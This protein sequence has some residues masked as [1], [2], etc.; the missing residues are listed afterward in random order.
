[1]KQVIKKYF[2]LA[3]GIMALLLVLF[4]FVLS[5]GTT[6]LETGTLKD[7]RVSS[8]L[9]KESAIKMLAASDENVEMLIACIDKISDLPD[10]SSYPVRDAA[11]MCFLGLKQQKNM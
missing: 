6:D 5:Q 11:E 10:S 7:W 3:L 8:I 9:R 1:M 2:K 4:V